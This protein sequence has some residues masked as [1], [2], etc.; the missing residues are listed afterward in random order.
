MTFDKI[1]RRTHLYLGLFLMPWLLIYGASSFIILHPSWF[2][3]DKNRDWEPFFEKD[4]NRP[5]SVQGREGT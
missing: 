3:A 4:Y 1:N 2:R 5:V